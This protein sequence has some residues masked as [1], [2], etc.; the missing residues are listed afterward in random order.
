MSKALE[1]SNNIENMTKEKMIEVIKASKNESSTKTTS[2]SSRNITNYTSKVIEKMDSKI[3]SY[4]NLYSDLYKK[5]LHIMDNFY[6]RWYSN[7]KEA[8]SK[9]A[10]ND[11]AL[12]MFDTYLKSFRQMALL[13][14]DMTENIFK[15]YVGY[16]LT[17]LDFYDQMINGN[18]ISFTKMF[19]KIN[20]L[21]RT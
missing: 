18:M 9:M 4:V 5:Y 2:V 17:A 1:K 21:N 12:T 11:T 7:Q 14:I 15:N 6:N 20:D 19:P 3:P 8:I 16:R 13:Q 10:V